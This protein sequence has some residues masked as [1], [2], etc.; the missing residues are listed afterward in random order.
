MKHALHTLT[1]VLLAPLA[2]LHAA[3][4]DR[5][6]PLTAPKRLILNDDGHNGFY[7]GRL[8]DAAT[9]REVP[10]R[11]R[12][13]QVGIYQWGVTLGTKVNYP[14]R[15]AELCGE[16]ISTETLAAVRDGDRTLAGLLQ[17]LR[18]D[19]VDTL[20]CIAE[21][22]HAADMQCYA[23]VRMNA[24]YPLKANGWVGDSMAR[25]FNSKFWWDHPE[26]RVRSRDGREQ[27]S[28]SYA[29]PEVRARVLGIVREVLERDVDGVDLDFLR[30]PPCFGYEESL[31]K[32]YQDRFHLDPQTIPDDHDERWLHYRAELMTGLLREIRQAV[33]EAA[34]KKGR[35]LGLS[36]R[37]DHANYLLWGCDV[38]VWLQERLLDILVVSQH[39]LGGWDFD[40]RPFVQKAKGTGC[41]VYLGE[42]ATIAG[43]DPTPG[44]VA[45]LKP[46][47]KA[48]ATATTMTE[49]MWFER[50]R[51]W[52]EQGAAGIHIFNGAPPSVLKYLGDP[53]AKQPSG[54]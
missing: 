3:D 22:C 29:F 38:D 36:A 5:I 6:A 28:L 46:G 51:H 30:H 39:G 10:Q 53:P 52:Y 41:A 19:G 23:S 7:T 45:K 14:S 54:I 33:D 2:A 17:K 44:D 40:L 26:W 34:K 32:G 11:M 50:A 15:I 8:K 12:G 42:E 20:Q 21:G 18:A 43:R 35:P 37:I 49:A 25:F 48:P 4:P 16:G 24:V 9:L 31:V 1:A 47:E 27:P 13:T